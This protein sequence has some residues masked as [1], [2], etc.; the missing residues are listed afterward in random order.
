MPESIELSVSEALEAA[1]WISACDARVE[2][3]ALGMAQAKSMFLQY[4]I[5]QK[6]EILQES[7]ET[8]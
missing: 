8:R 5:S 6:K 1:K 7:K 3:F 4:L 2:G